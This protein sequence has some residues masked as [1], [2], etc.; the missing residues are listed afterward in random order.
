MRRAALAAPPVPGAYAGQRLPEVRCTR[1]G[2]RKLAVL[3]ASVVAAAVVVMAAA[4]PVAGEHVSGR[5]TSARLPVAAWGPVS[6]ALGRGDPAY[7]AAGAGAGFVVRNPR[8]RLRAEFSRA[9]VS[10]RSG[11]ALLGLRLSGYGYGSSLRGLAAVAPTASANRVLYR[12]G[13][14]SEWYANG[15]LGLEQGFTLTARPAGRRVGPVTLALALSGNARAVLSSSSGG[16]TFSH[17]GSSLSYRGLVATDARG[18]TLPASLELHGRELLLRVND[19]GARYP[20]RVDPFV[21]Q[22]KLTASDGAAFDG[23]GESVGISGDTIVA[24]APGATVNGQ[25]DEGAAYVFV[26]PPGGWQ[27]ATQTAKLTPSGNGSDDGLFSVAISGDTIVAGAFNATVAGTVAEGAVY[28]FVEPRGGWRSETETATLTEAAGEANDGLGDSVAIE[29]D[30][31]VA[32]AGGV[33]VDGRAGQGAVEVFREP[34]GGWRDE[35][36][37]AVLTASD[38]VAGDEL[39][40]AVAIDGATIIAGAPFATV[41]G[42]SDEGAAYVFVEPRW[43]WRSAT[44]TAKLTISDGQANEVAGDAVAISRGTA[45]IGAEGATVDGDSNAGAAYVFTMPRWGW[46]SETDAAELTASDINPDGL[47]LLGSAVAIVGHTIVAGAP[48]ETLPNGPAGIFLEGAIYV[49]KMPPGGW[50]SETQTQT[51]TGS[52]ITTVGWLGI[53]LATQRDTIVAGAQVTF[54]GE[55][56]EQGAVYVFKGHGRDPQRVTENA[57]IARNTRA[58]AAQRR[59]AS[60]Y[61]A[62]QR[63]PASPLLALR[64]RNRAVC[65]MITTRHR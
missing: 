1:P 10:V 16:V 4:D 15:P 45:V 64:S 52:D 58:P 23:L 8:Q 35:T 41:D 38:G 30:T 53:S 40:A 65:S 60:C 48:F 47:Y 17:G 54:V 18:R 55:N 26:K 14:L 42:N 61:A 39:G 29:G 32:G 36:A 9:G 33:T 12:H 43:G 59:P 31:V 27:N 7:R 6:R 46:R 63:A 56:N 34:R 25:A 19:T 13:P 3:G 24:A 5:A 2:L 11:Q 50:R 20:L 51:L 37:S 62:L 22:A 28:V 57:S 44:E 49:Y 21:Q